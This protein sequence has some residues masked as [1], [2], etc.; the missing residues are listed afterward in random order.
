MQRKKFNKVYL[1]AEVK[2]FQ[3]KDNNLKQQWWTIIDKKKTGCVLAFIEDSEWF[4]IIS[5]ILGDK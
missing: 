2:P 5:P 3:I 4:N 1:M